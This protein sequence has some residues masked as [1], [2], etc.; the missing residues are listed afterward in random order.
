M[1]ETFEETEK[2]SRL[3]SNEARPGVQHENHTIRGVYLASLEHI[4]REQILSIA[5]N[6]LKGSFELN[7]TRISSLFRSM[8]TGQRTQVNGRRVL[9]QTLRRQHNVL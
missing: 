1:G 7:A 6:M 9:V 8:S 5:F 3:S 4:L 2:L